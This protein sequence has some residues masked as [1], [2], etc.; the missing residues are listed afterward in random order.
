MIFPAIELK[1]AAR[2][3]GRNFFSFCF[4]FVISSLQEE[5]KHELPLNLRESQAC[6]TEG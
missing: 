4:H 1:I 5:K 3:I 6:E 2:K